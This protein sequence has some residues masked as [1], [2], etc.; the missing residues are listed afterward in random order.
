MAVVRT[1]FI[2]GLKTPDFHPM[3]VTQDSY[4]NFLESAV[5]RWTESC[6]DFSSFLFL[7]ERVRSNCT[8]TVLRWV[9]DK[10][11]VRIISHIKS[12]WWRPQSQDWNPIDF[13]LCRFLVAKVFERRPQRIIDVNEAVSNFDNS[14]QPDTLAK[15]VKNFRKRVNLCFVMAGQH[16]QQNI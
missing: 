9:S 5:L 15:V 14:I 13:H 7:L 1:V 12:L 8:N 4:F 2:L 10:F 16:F 3:R 6:R 11:Q